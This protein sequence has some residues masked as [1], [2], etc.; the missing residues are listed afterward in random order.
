MSVKAEDVLNDA[1]ESLVEQEVTEETEN[2]G[3]AAEQIDYESEAREMG[4]NPEYSGP[5]KKTAQ[6]YY[7]DGL[8]IQPI[9]QAN[10]K[11][12][13]Q[14]AENLEARLR[15]HESNTQK[16]IQALQK[17]AERET[18]RKIAE[19][20]EE[21]LKAVKNADTEKFEQLEKE[22]KDLLKAPEPEK[23]D[24]K[25]IRNDPTIKVWEGENPWYGVDEELTDYADFHASRLRKKSDKTG[26]DFLDLVAEQ[27]RKQYPGKFKN[28]RKEN[29][30]AAAPSSR[31]QLAKTTS[32]DALPTSAKRDF[33]YAVRRGLVKDTTENRQQFAKDFSEAE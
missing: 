32:F 30:S 17:Q 8:K 13:R 1:D 10:L 28:P 16:S 22:E 18:E 2:D 11:K 7:E 6:E 25:D 33:D 27:V 4:W 5:N 20:R 21:K 24:P 15:E 19:I 12:E 9:L 31:Q 3:A 26:K 14:R 29:F 23:E